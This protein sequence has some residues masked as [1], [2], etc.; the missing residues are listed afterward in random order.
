MPLS[1]TFLS[2][3]GTSS[4]TDA[5]T[6]S[7]VRSVLC[8][9]DSLTQGNQDSTGITWPLL[10]AAALGDEV[11]V[12]NR[13]QGGYTSTEVA[14]GTGAINPVLGAFTIPTDTSATSVTVTSPTGTYRANGSGITYVWTGT[15]N[16]IAGTLT[17]NNTNGTW[18]FARAAGG[19]STPVAAG[20]T[21]HC[22]RDDALTGSLAVIWVGRNNIT[23]PAKLVAD[24][25][26]MI[27]RLSPTVRRY[28]VLGVTTQTTETTGVTA[29]TQ[30]LAANAALSAAYGVHYLD[31]RAALMS[32]GLARVNITATGNDTTDLANGTIPRSLLYSDGLHLNEYGYR[33]VAHA[34]KEQLVSLGWA[35]AMPTPI[36]GTGPVNLLTDP[37][38]E[39]GTAS[40]D[41]YAAN[42]TMARTAGAG[43]KSS[44]GARASFTGAG[45]TGAVFHAAYRTIDVSVPYSGAV[46]VRPSR[47]VTLLPIRGVYNG[48]IGTPVTQQ[49]GAG[50]VCL[51]G[52][53]TRLAI[54]STLTSGT[55]T[56]ATISVGNDAI[57]WV[58]GDYV[59]FDDVVLIAGSTAP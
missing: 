16:G 19:S 30:I 36:A 48:D 41:R 20:S 23:D 37:G 57:A 39:A 4:V 15:I 33:V 22:T 44:F 28:L 10:L 14:I 53:W 17:R 40:F 32:G 12:T 50:V 7:D 49:N 29:H 21:F 56:I 35:A 2:G 25:D 3:S 9:G 51:A 24:V 42:C 26:A 27:A 45:F 18:T 1:R 47:T 6:K 34:V 8:W 13:G 11:T 59:D 58:A 31:T 55:G 43:R 46:W 38:Y 52:A 54:S 5:A